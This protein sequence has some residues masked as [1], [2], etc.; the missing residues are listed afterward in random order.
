MAAYVVGDLTAQLSN[1]KVER[2]DRRLASID[3]MRT[4]RM[5]L[6]GLLWSGPAGHIFYGQLERAFAK[7]SAQ[8]A[9]TIAGKVMADQLFF[10]PLCTAVFFAW[11]NVAV[12]NTANIQSD[13]AQKLPPSVKAA[14]ALWVPAMTLN[15]AIVPPHMRILF[16]NATTILWTNILSNMAGDSEPAVMPEEIDFSAGSVDKSASRSL[17][18]LVWRSVRRVSAPAEPPAFT[19]EWPF[20]K[21]GLACMRPSLPAAMSGSRLSLLFEEDG[22]ADVVPDESDIFGGDSV[23]DPLAIE[24]L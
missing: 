9:S 21:E 7:Q 3:V 10:A 19:S 17:P 14:W 16:I 2:V 8:A 5:A 6:Y 1:S 22:A 15:M 11:A 13:V 20:G 18:A 4:V 23:A 24:V 12:G